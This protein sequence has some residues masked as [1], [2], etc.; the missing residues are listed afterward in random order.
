MRNIFLEKC[1]VS[2]RRKRKCGKIKKSRS[3]DMENQII[4]ELNNTLKYLKNSDDAPFSNKTVEEI[5]NILNETINQIR[6]NENYNNDEIKILFAPTGDIQ[7][8][9]IKNNWINEY[10]KIAEKMDNIT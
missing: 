5:A 6:K 10:I 8:T 3:V 2:L 9:A 4:E 7:E 1:A